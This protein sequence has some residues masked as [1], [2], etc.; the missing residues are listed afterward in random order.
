MRK[1]KEG[2]E[3]DWAFYVANAGEFDFCGKAIEVESDPNGPDAKRAF[4]LFDSQGKAVPCREPELLKKVI[5]AKGSVNLHIKEWAFG[6]YEGTF[7]PAELRRYLHSIDAP[8]WVEQAVKNQVVNLY[9]ARR[10]S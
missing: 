2:F 6:C 7:P 5:T 9:K 4:Q 8:A 3:R 10:A 1:Y